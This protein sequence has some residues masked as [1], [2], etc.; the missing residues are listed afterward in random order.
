MANQQNQGQPNPSTVGTNQSKDA[1]QEQFQ[2][3]QQ[4]GQQ[5]QQGERSKLQ[6]QQE[7]ADTARQPG[8]PPGATQG[9]NPNQQPGGG[10]S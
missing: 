5:G 2:P 7:Q 6:D 1:Q 8:L 3:S 10:K 9:T 4:G